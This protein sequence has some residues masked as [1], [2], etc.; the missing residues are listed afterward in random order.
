MRASVLIAPSV[1]VVML[2][3]ASGCSGSAGGSAG[4][5]AA[6]ASVSV[7]QGSSQSSSQTV[8]AGGGATSIS[9]SSV[10]QAVTGGSGA[11]AREHQP[12]D[13]GDLGRVVVRCDRG[14]RL[15]VGVEVPAGAPG[16]DVLLAAGSER[17]QHRAAGGERV[18]SPSAATSDVSARLRR[19]REQAATKIG[20]RHAGAGCAVTSVQTTHHGTG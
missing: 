18:W 17:V 4:R 2:L 11:V 15:A 14:G 5:S 9:Q 3:A 7:Q 8:S 6:A 12:V 13:F 16:V 1:G 10:Q 19:G 20:V